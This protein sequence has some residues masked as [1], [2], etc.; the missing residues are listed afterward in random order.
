MRLAYEAWEKSPW[1]EQIT[2]ELFFNNVLPYANVNEQRDD[3]RADFYERCLPMIAGAKTPTE[4][5][6]LLNKNLFR[7]INVKY[8]TKRNR[9][10]QG[11]PSPWKQ[12]SLRAQAYRSF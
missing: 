1:R 9:A 8:S 6:I 3:W 4:A 7:E 5:A 11:P 10:D 12:V 2:E